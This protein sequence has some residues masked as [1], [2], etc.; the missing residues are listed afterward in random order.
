MEE[1]LRTMAGILCH[2]FLTPGSVQPLDVPYLKRLPRQAQKLEH[3]GRN[4]LWAV[5]PSDYFVEGAGTTVGM[6]W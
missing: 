1:V 6:I 2:T 4:V 5:K 3:K